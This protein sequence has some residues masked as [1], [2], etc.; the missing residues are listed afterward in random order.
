MPSRLKYLTQ[1]GLATPQYGIEDSLQYEVYIGSSAYGCSS[2]TSDID[3]NGFF[4]PPKNMTFPH[5]AGYIKGYDEEE[6]PYIE[7]YNQHHIFDSSALNNTGRSYDYSVHSIVKFFKLCKNNNPNMVDSLF[8]PERCILFMT[9]LGQMVRDKRKLFLS[10]RCFHTFKGYAYQQLHKLRIKEPGENSK[11]KEIVDKFGYDCKFAYHIVR[12]MNEVEQILTEG[13]LDLERSKEQLKSIRNGEWKLE[14]IEHYFKFNE[15]RLTKIYDESA[16]IHKPRNS[17]IKD[18][19]MACLEQHFGTLKNCVQTV[20]PAI[21]A[22][23]DIEKII[24][25]YRK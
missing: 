14:E 16:L 8:V 1:K 19:L 9:P 2:D 18:L 21:K 12:L 4:I 24:Y 22:L 10:K 17:E 23:E 3:V 6:A 13:D 15:D 5:L 7:T 11:R 25:S 20:D